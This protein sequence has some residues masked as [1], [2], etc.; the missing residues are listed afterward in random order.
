MPTPASK[1]A[2][3]RAER[4]AALAECCRH[5]V[6]TLETE[7]PEIARLYRALEDTVTREEAIEAALLD[8]P[9]YPVSL[10]PWLELLVTES[11]PE[12][13]RHL[14]T[15]AT[16]SEEQPDGEPFDASRQPS[17]VSDGDSLPEAVAREVGG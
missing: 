1:P 12:L 16:A 13:L 5:L 14:W 6:R 17:L 9:F 11:A 8:D 10:R 3:V 2:A 4:A 7:L 15:L